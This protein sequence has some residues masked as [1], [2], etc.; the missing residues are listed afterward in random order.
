MHRVKA[1]L[2]L[3]KRPFPIEGWQSLHQ[4]GLEFDHFPIDKLLKGTTGIRVHGPISLPKAIRKRPNYV[5]ASF[6][7]LYLGGSTF[8]NI[9]FRSARFTGSKLVYL[10]FMKCDLSYA[11]FYKSE[12]KESRFEDANLRQAVFNRSTLT[13]VD[14][15]RTSLVGVSFCFAYCEDISF[16]GSD[17]CG[18][19]FYRAQLTNLSE[20]D[21]SDA[22]LQNAD[23]RHSC[24]IPA[25]LRSFL[26]SKGA[27]F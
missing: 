8:K 16:K 1:L 21:F 10:Q 11:K 18:A 20:K 24:G 7:G 26:M 27:L 5:S 9:S 6:N 25:P 14:F 17:L 3:N 13:K 15:L 23:F 2:L 12:I 22:K 19:R 4:Q